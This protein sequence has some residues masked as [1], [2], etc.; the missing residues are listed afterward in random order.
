MERRG[1]SSPAAW[2]LDRDVNP[3]RSK[4]GMGTHMAA[5]HVPRNRTNR[6]VTAGLDRWPSKT[7]LGL[8]TALAFGFKDLDAQKRVFFCGALNIAEEA[9]SMPAGGRGGK[10]AAAAGYGSG[11]E[12]AKGENV[13]KCF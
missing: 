5:R 10:A 4:I 9:G 12:H 2:R 11:L 6:L 13:M 1:K 3:T 8:Q 7:E